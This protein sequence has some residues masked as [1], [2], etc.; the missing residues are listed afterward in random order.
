MVTAAHCVEGQAADSI[1][2]NIIL[3]SS[4]SPHFVLKDC[5][6]WGVGE[7]YFCCLLLCS[8]FNSDDDKIE[9]K[10]KQSNI[11]NYDHVAP[12]MFHHTLMNDVYRPHGP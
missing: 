11:Y 6:F 1:S 7:F 2:V 12:P 9:D 8:T 4:F 5:I 3:S 10:Q